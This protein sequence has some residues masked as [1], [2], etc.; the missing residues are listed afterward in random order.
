MF[1]WE[2]PPH[3]SG[4][5]G[6]ACYGLATALARTGTAVLFVLPY[7]VDV[8]AAGVEFCF[9]DGSYSVDRAVSSG[10][11]RPSERDSSLPTAVERYAQAA[12]EIATSNP[13]DVIHAHDWLSFPAAIVAKRVSGCPL[14]VHIHATEH[15][16]TGGQGVNA[17]VAAIE[18]LGLECADQ[19]I[20]V[21]HQTKRVLVQAYGVDPSRVSV[22]HNGVLPVSSKQVT[23]PLQ[24]LK[25]RSGKTVLFLGRITVQKGPEYFLRTAK[26]VVELEPST[27]FVMAGDGDLRPAMIRYAASLGIARQV[28]FP[29]FVRDEELAALYQA[30]DLF[31]LPSVSEPFGIAPLEALQYGVPVLISKQAGVGE[32]LPNALRCDFWDIE[33][34]ANQIVSSLRYAPL[35]RSLKEFGHR[36]ASNCRWEDAAAHCQ[37]LYGAVHQSAGMVA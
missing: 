18:R 6:T 24:R 37:Q 15:D 36:D 25:E 19:V 11:S 5:L 4:G 31:V 12:R 35:R 9:A 23:P 10:Y 17:E 33:A 14:I 8:A 34:M 28:F 32:V 29:G 16:R 2:F 3:N 21:S 20:A 22:V 1:G 13:H 27:R 7:R 26:R 30:A